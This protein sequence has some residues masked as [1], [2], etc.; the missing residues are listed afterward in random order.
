M[1]PDRKPTA[2]QRMERLLRMADQ[3]R[4]RLVEAAARFEAANQRW[5]T[6][7]LLEAEWYAN[8]WEA[9]SE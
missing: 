9:T 6:C 3:Q 5:V 4:E 1:D 8:G 2:R 7:G